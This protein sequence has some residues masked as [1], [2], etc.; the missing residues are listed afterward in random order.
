MIY[1]PLPLP[2]P[3]DD[4]D[5]LRLG[6]GSADTGGGTDSRLYSRR[7]GRTSSPLP[8]HLEEAFLISHCGRR[9][10]DGVVRFRIPDFVEERRPGPARSH[11]ADLRRQLAGSTGQLRLVGGRSAARGTAPRSSL[12]V[13]TI[14]GITDI[15]SLARLDVADPFPCPVGDGQGH[16]AA[17]RLDVHFVAR[18]WNMAVPERTR[19]QVHLEGPFRVLWHGPSGR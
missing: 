9:P 7:R 8:L 13:L 12:A 18:L 16:A 17:T 10:R 3:P 1:P 2:L 14:N 4:G 19:C 6:H 11:Q 5:R 15:A